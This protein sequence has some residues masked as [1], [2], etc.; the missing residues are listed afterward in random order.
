MQFPESWLRELQP[1]ADDP[2][3]SDTLTMAWK[4]KS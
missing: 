2:E 1:A 4:W 3:L